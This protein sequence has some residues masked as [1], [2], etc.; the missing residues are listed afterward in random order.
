MRK[1]ISLFSACLLMFSLSLA[2]TDTDAGNTLVKMGL[3]SGYPDGSLG[4]EKDITRAEFCTLVAK[5]LKIN[6][7]MS[8]KVDNFSDLKDS[9]WAYK[10]VMALADRGVINGYADSTFRPSKTLT[11][12]ECS[13]ILIGVLGY[14]EEM[15]GVWPNNVMDLAENLG[16]HKDL[17]FEKHSDNMTRGNVSIMLM[18]AMN[19]VVKNNF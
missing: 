1:I 16:L 4:L 8:F 9:H 10:S 13:A 19:V 18:N 14:K 2:I 15:V 7:E 6:N 11:Y 5:M 17:K 12:A 3:M